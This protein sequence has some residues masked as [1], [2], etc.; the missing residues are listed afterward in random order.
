M[1][2]FTVTAPNGKT[3]DVTAPEGATG[4]QAIAYVQRMLRQV[5][6]KP[7]QEGF[8]SSFA[9]SAKT[10]GKAPEAARFAR[11]G[12]GAAEREKLLAA[13]ASER[14][15]TSFSDVISGEGSFSDY[16]KQTA[17]SS[18]GYLA[19]PGLASLGA[20][21]LKAPTP[22]AKAAGVAVLGGQYLVDALTRQAETQQQAVEEGRT[23]EETSLGRATAAA[24][25]ETAL[26][27]AGFK[28]FAPVFRAFPVVGKIF[29]GEGDEVAQQ[30][31]DAAK[32][33]KLSVANGVMRGI[34]KGA[35][36]EVPQEIGQSM[37]ERWQAGLSLSDSSALQEYG[38]A[39]AG[40]GILGGGLGGVGGALDVSRARA[41][42]RQEELIKQAAKEAAAAKKTEEAQA[43]EEATAKVEKEK[44][45]TAAQEARDANFN[46]AVAALNAYVGEDASKAETAVGELNKVIRDA[47]GLDYN[48]VERI[49]GQLKKNGL[50]SSKDKEGI[51]TATKLVEA[52]KAEDLLGAKFGGDEEIPFDTAAAE[53]QRKADEQA[54]AEAK[55]KADEQ[56]AAEAQRKADEQAA[57]EAKRKADEQ[58]AA[59]DEQ[60]AKEGEKG[61][62]ERAETDV[63][64]TG[65]A[66]AGA[67][68]LVSGQT[69]EE[70]TT[71]GTGGQGLAGAGVPPTG[72]DGTEIESEPALTSVQKLSDECYR[73]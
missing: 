33:G 55:R 25:G 69:P 45:K 30:F 3:Y 64:D 1:P 9:K 62:T 42:A 53:A 59:A 6:P 41:G 51:R 47:T 46:K 67:E 63:V 26:D 70:Q 49:I 72:V 20:T 29:K 39:L 44:K 5:A 57:A 22:Y 8:I 66:G 32:N 36:I 18:A 12:A 28:Y 21:L 68:V 14:P 50:V 61:G 65:A 71:K 43:A 13:T 4:E 73:T 2:I 48:A 24:A 40:A 56:A 17:G 34:G 11:E 38:E 27:V 35:A 15:T 16:L 52:P 54:A 60:A 31:V 23:P 7:E 19:A 58:A 10:L 37:L